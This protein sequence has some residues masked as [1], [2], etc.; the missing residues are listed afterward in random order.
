MTLTITDKLIESDVTRHN[1]M[2]GHDGWDV[3]WFRIGR[4]PEAHQVAERRAAA[5]AVAGNFAVDAADCAEL[6]DALGLKPEDGL[7]TNG[8]KVN[9]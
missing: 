6:L 5:R 3:S 2:K 4:T 8:K 7:T 9:A 1:A